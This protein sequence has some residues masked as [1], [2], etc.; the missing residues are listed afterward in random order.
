MTPP[1]TQRFKHSDITDEAVLAVLVAS[2]TPVSALEIAERHCVAV[3]RAY[4]SRDREK[5]NRILRDLV[6]RDAVR[7]TGH[8]DSTGGRPAALWVRA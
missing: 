7:C 2:R 8:A 1:M 4:S 5:V 6:S 3:G